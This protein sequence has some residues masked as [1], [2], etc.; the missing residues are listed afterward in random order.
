M[1]ANLS[2]I[3]ETWATLFD[4]IAHNP[5]KGSKL[6]AFYRIK[7]INEQNEFMRNQNTAKSPCMAYSVLVDAEASGTKS[8]NYAHTIYFL[9]RAKTNSLAKSAKQDDD[10]G[11]NIQM[12]MDDF[13]QELLAYLK[14]LRHTGRCPLSNT[15]FDRATMEALR[16]IDLEKA[17]WASIPIKYGEWHILGLQLEQIAPRQLCINRAHYTIPATVPADSSAVLD[18]PS[19]SVPDGSS[20][21]E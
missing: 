13:V 7:T 10:L 2:S 3:L 5:A 18:A 15:T 16:G 19:D 21:G 11:E 8:V 14:E 17:Q 4:A 6:K 1:K 20:S 12:E 9:S